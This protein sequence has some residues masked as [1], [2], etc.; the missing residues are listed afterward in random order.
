MFGM[1]APTRRGGSG[2]V[3][4]AALALALAVSGCGSTAHHA[5]TGTTAVASAARV[6]AGGQAASTHGA[7]A[8]TA[9][10]RSQPRSGGSVKPLDP[11]QLVPRARAQS[12]SG[13]RVTAT[14]EAPLG[15]TC[16]YRL[17]AAPGQITLAVHSDGLP[18]VLG[19]MS[20]RHA[21]VV[22]GRR[23]YCGRVGLPTLVVGLSAGRYLSV[24]A[25]CGLASRYAD[26]ALAAL[27]A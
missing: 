26:A 15:P 25:P 6:P 1:R 7:R 2:A 14:T 11:C 23:G 24:T 4:T 13:A 21:V 3:L 27:R 5:V 12:L 17:S 18:V 9:V 10:P 22:H 20:A 16:I 8:Q 19:Q